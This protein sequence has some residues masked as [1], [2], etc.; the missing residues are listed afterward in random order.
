LDRL[1][2]KAVRATRQLSRSVSGDETHES[3]IDTEW[4]QHL[5]E[6]GIITATTFAVGVAVG[7]GGK[8][9]MKIGPVPWDLP[10]GGA[11]VALS[12]LRP[13]GRAAMP[14]RAVGA[15]LLATHTM[16]WGR[17]VGKWWRDSAHLPPLIDVAGE[18]P[19]PTGGG[20]LSDEELASVARRA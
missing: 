3:I 4:K 7:R 2:Q 14:L 15:G 18:R 12:L 11:L 8:D 5:A 10:V 16:T 1:R 19:A 17:G 6:V 20:A 13:A 9:A